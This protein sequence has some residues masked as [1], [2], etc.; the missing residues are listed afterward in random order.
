VKSKKT[1][2]LCQTM[3]RGLQYEGNDYDGT[4]PEIIRLPRIISRLDVDVQQVLTHTGQSYD[5][6]LNGV[7]S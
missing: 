5:D 2:D 4:R 6:E 1:S 7:S 3:L